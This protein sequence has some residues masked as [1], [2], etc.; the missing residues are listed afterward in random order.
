[1]LHDATRACA[2]RLRTRHA[3]HSVRR[4]LEVVRED[5]I[6]RRRHEP[7]RARARHV[8]DGFARDTRKLWL[9]FEYAGSAPL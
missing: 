1:M 6:D 9:Q 8:A 2:S 4:N 3:R 5:R 7:L